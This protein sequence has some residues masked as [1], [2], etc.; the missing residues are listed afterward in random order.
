MKPYLHADDIGM[1]A[2]VTGNIL[3]AIDNGSVTSTSL[4]VNGHDTE[5]ACE[6]LLKRPD[7]RVS[8]HLNLT[9]GLYLSDGARKG[10]KIA[11]GWGELMVCGMIGRSKSLLRDE[12]EAQIAAYRSLYLDEMDPTV[13][14]RLDGHLHVHCIPFVFDK[15]MEVASTYGVA[16]MRFPSEPFFFRFDRTYIRKPVLLNYVKV[17]LLRYLTWR[18]RA[19]LIDGEIDIDS[20]FVGVAFTGFMQL[21]QIRDALEAVSGPDDREVEI[22]VHP[23]AASPQ[24]SDI[25]EGRPTTRDYYLSEWRGLELDLAKSDAMKDL[26]AQKS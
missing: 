12:I 23:G 14:F 2:A 16:S 17:A 13:P 10:E 4:V 3:D 7:V 20:A 9:E 21:N 8:L 25:W 11:H 5:R 18:M 1:S 6:E 26:L 22:L 24:E 19:R 15:I